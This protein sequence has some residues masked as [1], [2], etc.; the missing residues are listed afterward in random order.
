[1]VH[2]LMM[3][4][5]CVSHMSLCAGADMDDDESSCE[6]IYEEEEEE[7]QFNDDMEV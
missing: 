3:F 1:M 5:L 6:V 2:G 4:K 7:S